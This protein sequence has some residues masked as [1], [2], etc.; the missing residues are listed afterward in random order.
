MRR[1]VF[2]ILVVFLFS[3]RGIAQQYD[4]QTFDNNLAKDF[5]YGDYD[6]NAFNMVRY[7]KDTTAHAL[8]LKELGR[9]W[10][11]S[12]GNTTTLMFEYHVKIKLF[13][14]KAFNKGHIEIPVYI[15]D[16]GTYEEARF[17]SINAMTYYKDDKGLMV[18]VSLNPD[19]ITTIKEN[20]HWSKV[21]FNLPH[22]S[23]GCIIEY[24][25][26]LESPFL[27]RFHT[28]EFQSDIPKLYSE[29]EA[30][31]P[32]VF[33]YNTTLRGTL[34]LT[35]DTVAVEKSCFEST[36]VKSDCSVEDYK[37]TNVPAF[38]VEPYMASPKNFLSALYYQI[39]ESTKLNNF[40]NLNYSFQQDVGASWDVVDKGLKFNENFG[41]QLKHTSIFKDKIVPVIAGKTDTLEKA[42][43]IYAYIQKSISFNRINNIYSD[44]GLKKALDKHTGNVADVNLSLV[45]ALNSAGINANAVL[46][47][48]RDNGMTTGLYPGL[49]EF[50]Y[51]IAATIING[52]V[53]LMDA[54]DPV[55]PF[56]MLPLKCLNGQGRVIPVD[57]P[58]Y[59]INV[60]TP[61]REINSSVL[62]LTLDESGKMTGTITDYSKGYAAYEKRKAYK[63]AGNN[64]NLSS[65]GVTILKSDIS[66]ADNADLPLT[67]VY[68]VQVNNQD[69]NSTGQFSFVPFMMGDPAQKQLSLLDT[70][71][72]NP[73]K[74]ATRIHLI[75]FGMPSA[76]SFTLILHLPANYK[77]VTPPQ[78]LTDSIPN[79]GAGLTTSFVSDD[80][81][82]TYTFTYH[83][84]NPVYSVAE[85]AYIKDIFDKIILSEKAMLVLKKQ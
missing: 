27:D 37:I 85:Y 52:K 76:R 83:L 41:I 75:D 78:N 8:V 71:A 21:V 26:R 17:S 50:N 48:T 58:S 57:R 69:K 61:Q 80:N 67:R 68:N 39:T 53:Y 62:D 5:T 55:L 30:H 10:I 9:A 31:I 14:S 66:N 56:G 7:D 70:L 40:S 19:S 34:K 79:N 11:A 63:L 33:A 18:A 42:K 13:N 46:I 22:I 60:V 25:Y 23:N 16:N 12:N 4:S 45:T 49:N 64:L 77:V 3:N 29:Y 81:T 74:S 36:N 73:F 6:Q 32:N 43:A 24:R 54:T 59:W 72:D 2:L 51:V 1:I 47:S 82:V 28:W 44:E 15:Q 84:D 38:V 65:S 20:E 35:K